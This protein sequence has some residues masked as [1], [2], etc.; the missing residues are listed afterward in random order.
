MK[1]NHLLIFM[2]NLVITYMNYRDIQLFC[3]TLL[4]WL[5]R[6]STLLRVHDVL[7]SNLRRYIFMSFSSKDLLSWPFAA[8]YFAHHDLTEEYGRA[9]VTIASFGASAAVS[10]TSSDKTFMA[11]KARVL[12]LKKPDCNMLAMS[13]L[14]K[15][16]LGFELQYTESFA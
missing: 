10:K 12:G 1:P 11:A 13:N 15:E 6:D 8:I 2:Y 14:T 7:G 9:A 4:I 3:S 16:F 5:L